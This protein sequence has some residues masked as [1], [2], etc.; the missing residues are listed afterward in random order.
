M[1]DLCW[2]IRA[3][4]QTFEVAYVVPHLN[5]LL[6]ESAPIAIGWLVLERLQRNLLVMDDCN[7]GEIQVAAQIGGDDPRLVRLVDNAG[8]RST[9]DG[10][11]LGKRRHTYAH[12]GLTFGSPKA[13]A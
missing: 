13:R 11:L 5:L 4:R 1:L 7:R 12:R 9:L 10:E 3:D 8:V 6:D 2:V